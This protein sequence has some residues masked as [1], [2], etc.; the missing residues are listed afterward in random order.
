MVETGST[1]LIIENIVRIANALDGASEED[2]T[3][4]GSRIR[5]ALGRIADYFEDNSAG[6][7]EGGA[8]ALPAVTAA[9]NG[10]VLKVVDG[11]WAA[12]E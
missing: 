1:D 8:S 12:A 9:D 6:G 2:G 10:K 11:A 3:R 4:T 7:G 5:D